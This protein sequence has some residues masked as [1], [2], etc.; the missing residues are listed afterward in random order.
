METK[1]K[2]PTR[3]RRLHDQ[4]QTPTPGSPFNRPRQ[5]VYAIVEH[6]A[7]GKSKWIDIGIAFRNRDGSINLYLEKDPP[8]LK[9]QVREPF[10]NRKPREDA[11]HSNR[12][13]DK[14]WARRRYGNK[15]SQHPENAGLHKKDAA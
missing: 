15:A 5:A 9:L 6:E 11:P 7:N 12:R 1:E 13:A 8:A 14:E 10:E 3:A 4:N 2:T